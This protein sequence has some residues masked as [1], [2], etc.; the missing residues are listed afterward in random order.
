MILLCPPHEYFSG[1][2]FDKKGQ[3]G[4][5]FLFFSTYNKIIHDMADFHSKS[6]VNI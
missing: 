1:S 2:H 6:F 5:F 3:M 4:L